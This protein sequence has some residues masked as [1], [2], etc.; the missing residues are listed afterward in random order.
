MRPATAQ[1]DYNHKLY[2]RAAKR[3]AQ[4]ND[5]NIESLKIGIECKMLNAEQKKKQRIAMISHNIR[6]DNFKKEQL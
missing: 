1:A 4:F 3:H 2:D 6:V 5:E